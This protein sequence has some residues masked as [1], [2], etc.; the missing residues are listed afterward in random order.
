MSAAPLTSKGPLT[1]HLIQA[2]LQ[3]S[4]VGSGL[5][6]SLHLADEDVSLQHLLL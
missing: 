2:E 3:E 5:E 4:M 1:S 6:G